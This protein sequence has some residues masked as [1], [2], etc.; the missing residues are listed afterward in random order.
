MADFPLVSVVLPVYNQARYLPA[1]LDGVLAQV[2]PHCELIVVD[3]GS[4][5]GTAQVLAG[6]GERHRFTV[7]SQANQGL[8]CALNTGFARARGDYLTWTS[9][10]NVMLPDMLAVLVRAL[11]Q[12]PSVGLVYADFDVMDDEGHELGQLRTSDY[13]RYLLPHSNLV[14]CC[15]LYRREC[16]ERLGGY[17]PK[18]VYSED[19]EY[20]IRLSEH[21]R[22]KRVP[23]LLYRYRFHPASMTSDVVRD[24]ARGMGGATFEACIRRRMPVRWYMGKLKW[25]WLRWAR[26]NHPAVAERSFL[27]RL[28]VEASHCDS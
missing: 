15:F 24:T 10:D 7:V 20:W 5:D 27:R 11:D 23:Q 25:K 6:Y 17:D 18:F 14:H 28:A 1:A 16:M 19:W 4:V 9:S 12:D 2:Y 8:P 13:D 22:L 26:K 21:Y 3:D